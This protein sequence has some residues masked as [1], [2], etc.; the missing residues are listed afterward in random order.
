MQENKIKQFR[1]ERN[2]TQKEVANLVGITT[3]Y[4]GMI[5]IGEREPALKVAQKLATFFNTSIEQLFFNTANN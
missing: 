3:S 2:L 4:Y 5:E 1:L